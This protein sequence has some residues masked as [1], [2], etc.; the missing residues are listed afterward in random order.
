MAKLGNHHI[1]IKNELLIKRRGND[2][3]ISFRGNKSKFKRKR[4]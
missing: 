3:I 1:Y 4:N 2:G